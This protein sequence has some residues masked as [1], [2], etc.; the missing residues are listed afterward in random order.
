MPLQVYRQPNSTKC[1]I[2]M[3]NLRL[4][5]DRKLGPQRLLCCPKTLPMIWVCTIRVIQPVSNSTSIVDWSMKKRD[6]FKYQTKHMQRVLPASS[7]ARMRANMICL[8]EPVS[9]QECS[10]KRRLVKLALRLS[11][12]TNV[13]TVEPKS[14]NRT[15]NSPGKMRKAHRLLFVANAIRNISV[16]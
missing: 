4:I 9:L 15:N 14:T 8:W 1:F 7:T 6:F 10:S 3:V 11:G 5:S 13:P 12:Q 2:E 16:V